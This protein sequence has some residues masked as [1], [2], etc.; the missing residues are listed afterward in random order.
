MLILAM[1]LLMK[2]EMIEPAKP[3]T[4]ANTK[5]APTFRL[6]PAML[7]KLI[8]VNMLTTD[9]I[10]PIITTTA[11]LVRM[12]SAIRFIVLFDYLLCV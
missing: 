5:S 11:M 2:S 9:K 7:P 4:R 12:K 10:T 8:P 3:T 6:L 1:D